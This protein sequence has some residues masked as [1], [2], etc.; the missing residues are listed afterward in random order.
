[1]ISDGGVVVVIIIISIVVGADHNPSAHSVVA[2]VLGI[3]P[4]RPLNG[5]MCKHQ[6]HTLILQ[7]TSPVV[8]IER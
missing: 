1:M 5:N 2:G 3:L 4:G 8:D 6:A 7:G